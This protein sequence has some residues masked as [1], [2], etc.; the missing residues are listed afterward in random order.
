MQFYF[1]IFH[2][3]LHEIPSAHAPSITFA[4]WRQS[5]PLRDSGNLESLFYPRRTFF[6]T[7]KIRQ[8]FRLTLDLLLTNLEEFF[9]STCDFLSIFESRL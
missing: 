5:Y 2:E 9:P 3:I 8:S 6:R 7:E 4:I 1:V